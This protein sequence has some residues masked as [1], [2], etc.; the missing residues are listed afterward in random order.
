MSASAPEALTLDAGQTKFLM[1]VFGA[2]AKE[3]AAIHGRVMDDYERDQQEAAKAFLDLRLAVELM[4]VW[5]ERNFLDHE[6]NV[7]RLAEAFDDGSLQAL[8]SQHVL[9]R[10]GDKQL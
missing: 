6:P 2:R 4:L 8:R 3:S 1:D 7:R 10:A 9:D 5:A